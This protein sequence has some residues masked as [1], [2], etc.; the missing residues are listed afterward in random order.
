MSAIGAKRTW[1]IALHMSA[2]G[3]KADKISRNNGRRTDGIFSEIKIHSSKI[4]NGSQW[5]DIAARK[6]NHSME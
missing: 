4:R 3:G 6:P 1:P 5:W 2:F